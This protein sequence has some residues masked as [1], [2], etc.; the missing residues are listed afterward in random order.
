MTCHPV[1]L[2][3]AVRLLPGVIEKL[4]PSNFFSI[5][6]PGR[7]TALVPV[8][9]SPLPYFNAAGLKCLW[10]FRNLQPLPCAF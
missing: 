9:G 10:D 2:K 5:N 8:L 3:M 6:R 7:K 4:I 1:G